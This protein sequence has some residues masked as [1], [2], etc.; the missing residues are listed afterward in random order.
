MRANDGARAWAIPFDHRDSNPPRILQ[1]GYTVGPPNVSVD[2]KAMKV[3]GGLLP[4]NM[5][6]PSL[7]GPGALEDVTLNPYRRS[8]RLQQVVFEMARD[9]A[10]Q[11]LAQPE[12]MAQAVAEG[13]REAGAHADIKR[14][15]ELVPE[16]VAA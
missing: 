3:V 10:K 7:H 11:Y 4:T 15:P 1:A 8:H 9:L 14:V 5:G 6:R 12:C 2:V 13:V 16:D